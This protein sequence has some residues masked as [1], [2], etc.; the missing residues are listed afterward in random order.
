MSLFGAAHRCEELKSPL[1]KI[2]QIYPKLM[3]PGASISYLKKIQITWY[4]LWVLLTSNWLILLNRLYPLTYHDYIYCTTKTETV[5]T[6][7]QNHIYKIL[8]R[9]EEKIFQ[10]IPLFIVLTLHM[11]TWRLPYNI[12]L[13]TV[14]TP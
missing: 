3:K 14:E 5:K 8:E 1:P 9:L 10:T 11:F 6:G 12:L 7:K 2:C 13:I 4:T